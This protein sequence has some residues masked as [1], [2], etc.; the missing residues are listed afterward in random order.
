MSNY[1]R[2]YING[3]TWFF[4]VNLKNRKS[5]L[6]V[7]Q[8]AELRSAI[9]RV[10]NTKPFQ[11]DAF[12]VLPEHLH[13]IW[14]LPENDCD[15]SS[16]WREFEKLFTKSI[17]RREVW[18]PRFWEHAIRD[19]DDYRYHKNYI[20]INPVKHGWVTRVQDWPFSTFHRD[21]RNGVYPLDWAGDV[22]DLEAGERR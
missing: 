6:L 8:I 22:R 12:V 9:R 18:Q 10:K 21:V 5:D 7:R 19:D 15:F 14:T 17:I 16:R 3:G 2:Y 4:T 20:Y 13:C 1:R 11:I